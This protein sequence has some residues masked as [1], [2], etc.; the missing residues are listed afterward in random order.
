MTRRLREP[1]VVLATENEGKIKE[2]REFM[3][4]HDLLVV[5]VRDQ[6]IELPEETESTFPGNAMLKARFAAN[7]AGLPAIADDSGIAVKALDGRPG[8]HT[9]RWAETPSG[10]DFGLAMEKTWR[11]LEEREAPEPRIARFCCAIC[12]AWPDGDAAVFEGE[13]RGRFVW[14][15]RGDLGFGFDPVFQ[16]DGEGR[17]FAEMDP[18]EKHRMSHRARAFERFCAACLRE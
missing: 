5:S 4:P 13:V 10:R 15:M 8:I 6:G 14:P 9:A 2:F 3:A 16:P 12:V 11:L 1:V 17:T 18:R 7:A